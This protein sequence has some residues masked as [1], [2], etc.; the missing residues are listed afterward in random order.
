MMNTAS[1]FAT[2]QSDIGI[3]NWATRLSILVAP[4]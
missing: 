2:D 4:Q 1:Q 3:V